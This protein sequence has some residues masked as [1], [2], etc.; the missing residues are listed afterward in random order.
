VPSGNLLD[1]AL[2]EIF[3]IAGKKIFASNVQPDKSQFQLSTPKLSAD[4]YHAYIEN[5]IGKSVISFVK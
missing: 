4:A 2:V 5:K 3:T 1:P